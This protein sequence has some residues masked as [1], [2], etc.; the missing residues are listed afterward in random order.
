MN[1]RLDFIRHGQPQGGS[2]YRGAD[3]DDPLSELGWQQMWQAVGE[4]NHWDQIICSPM[5]RCQEFA[6][7]LADKHGLPLHTESDFRE[8]GFGEWT[9]HSPKDI[10]QQYPQAYR[11]FY[12]D[13]VNKRPRNAEDLHKF[14]KRVAHAMQNAVNLFEGKR[15]LIVAHAGV[16]RAALGHVMQAPAAAW[17]RV[18]VDNAAISRFEFTPLGFQLVFHNLPGLDQVATRQV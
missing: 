10:Q 5:H 8:V 17:Y 9:G 11:D 13:P 7:A 4:K 3:I 16:M 6:Q 15:L 1:T 12:A 14:G 18:K 2:L